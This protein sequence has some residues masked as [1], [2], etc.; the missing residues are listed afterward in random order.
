MGERGERGEREGKEKQL[1][2][3]RL[4][5]KQPS[6]GNQPIQLMINEIHSLLI[7]IEASSNDVLP[8]LHQSERG[9]TVTDLI[10][11]HRC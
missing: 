9:S 8:T 11:D 6:M 7:L 5:S 4:I 3:I 1:V 2:R 10:F